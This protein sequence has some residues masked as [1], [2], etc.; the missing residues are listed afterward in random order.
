MRDNG[1]GSRGDR[2]CCVSQTAGLLH[3]Y[4]HQNSQEAVNENSCPRNGCPRSDEE[5]FLADPGMTH[6]TPSPLCTSAPPAPA[7]VQVRANFIQSQRE[8]SDRE[9]EREEV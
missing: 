8:V 5:L 6:F 9:R 1:A 3:G 4:P 2:H 7:C